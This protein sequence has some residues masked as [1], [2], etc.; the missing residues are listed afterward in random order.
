MFPA[1]APMI[2]TFA[3]VQASKRAQMQAFVPTWIFVVGYLV[4]WAQP[5]V[6]AWAAARWTENAAAQS[7]WLME[8]GARLSGGLL[9]LAGLYQLTPLK[10]RCLAKCRSPLDFILGEWR[11]GRIGAMRMGMKH[12]LYC[13]GC[14][15]HLFVIL[16]PLGIMNITGMALVTL[17]I[18]IEKTVAGGHWVS[19][20]TAVPIIII[21]AVVMVYPSAAVMFGST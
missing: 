11:D 16:F 8:N 5:G 6:L 7:M 19:R 2:L 3:R 10:H 13:L 9:V 20:L 14:C 4:V 1:A 15:W 18:F 21:G 12:G 17:L